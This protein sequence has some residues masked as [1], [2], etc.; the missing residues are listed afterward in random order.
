MARLSWGALGARLRS[1]EV[2]L[3]LSVIA[4]NLGNRWRGCP[5]GPVL[6]KRIDNWPLASGSL[7]RE[8]RAEP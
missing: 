7:P 1:N 8:R 2:R 4:H 6:P 5:L 3:E